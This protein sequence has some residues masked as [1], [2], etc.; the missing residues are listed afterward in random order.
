MKKVKKVVIPNN[1]NPLQ[2][3]A[4]E[5]EAD[6]KMED[7]D[8]DDLFSWSHVASF[9]IYKLLSTW[10]DGSVINSINSPSGEKVSKNTMKKLI[11]FCN[12]FTLDCFF[13]LFF[14]LNFKWMCCRHRLFVVLLLVNQRNLNRNRPKKCLTVL[15][16]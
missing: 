7:E 1:S 10:D 6:V 9:A 13:F 5:P 16:Q 15:K 3:E 2:P 4:A 14:L 11:S 8:E 12:K